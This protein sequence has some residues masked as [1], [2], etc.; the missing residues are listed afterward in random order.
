MAKL[1]KFRTTLTILFGAFFVASAFIFNINT[2][3]MQTGAN[4]IVFDRYDAELGQTKIFVMNADGTNVTDLGNGFEPSWSADGAKIAYTDG[5]SETYDIWTMNADGSEKTQLTQ[6]YRSY[7][8]AWSPDGSRIAFV[9][10]H[11][12]GYHVY[13]INADGTNQQRLNITAPE[14]TSEY[15]PS[16][17]ADGTKVV[18]LAQK[19]INGLARNDYYATDAYGL[20]TTTQLTN[21]NAILEQ[22]PAA[23]SPNGSQIIFRYQFGLKAF[24]LDGTNQI[25]ALT[26]TSTDRE[27][28]YAPNGSKIIFRRGNLLHVMNA[29]GSEVTNLDVI[30]NNPDWNPS[31]VFPSPTPTVTPTATPT[32]QITAD[33]AVTVN[34]STNSVNIGENVT[35]T[36][37]VGNGGANA[38]TGVTLT[39]AFPT[40]L[41]LVSLNSSQGSCG[42]ASG[43][44]NCQIGMLSVSSAATVT[45]VAAPNATGSIIT[46]FNATAIETDPNIE[47][48]SATVNVTAV[49]QCAQV[50]DHPFEVKKLDWRSDERTGTDTLTLTLRNITNENLDPRLIFVFDNLPSNVTI[51]PRVV[52]GFTQCAAPL[53]SPYIVAYAPNK[54]EWKPMQTITITVPFHNPTRA[55]IPYTWRLYTGNV[56][57]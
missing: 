43:Q 14:V 45:L 3:Q 27:P 17:S 36:I 28:D 35:Y 10:D 39:S 8:P 50:F 54:K 11:E 2:A 37:N 51:D 22:D 1:N 32:P 31:A 12:G 46:Q 13:V 6:N 30:G 53:N 33:L 47:N 18:F 26:A 38:A 9:S 34:A 5:N 21:V 57:P 41:T 55:G 29:D 49:G 7:A 16:W 25:T 23:V 19:V 20:G 4:T 56:N 42:L 24:S 40:S 15:A 52:A 48:N 44:L